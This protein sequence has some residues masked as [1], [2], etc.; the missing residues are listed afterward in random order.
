[1]NDM[2][3]CQFA[4][5]WKPKGKTQWSKTNHA[6]KHLKGILAQA[7]ARATQSNF[8]N[9]LQR[10][11]KSCFTSGYH[12]V[13]HFSKH[14]QLSSK[15]PAQQRRS[16]EDIGAWITLVIL[17][18]WGPFVRAKAWAIQDCLL[19]QVFEAQDRLGTAFLIRASGWLSLIDFIAWF[20]GTRRSRPHA[21]W[22]RG[23]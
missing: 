16:H 15:A 5:T 23:G 13:F 20:R 2:C 17:K 11:S 12:Q 6:D 18:A 4:G 19:I 7:V 21:A 22:T 1:M 10:L 8:V 3:L 9:V 14:G